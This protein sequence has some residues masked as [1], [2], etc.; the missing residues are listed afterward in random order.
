MLS[1]IVFVVTFLI[2]VFLPTPLTVILTI[3]DMLI[4]DPIPFADE[5][6]LALSLV[7]KVR[8]S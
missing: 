8:K 2:G 6:G 4:P 1:L 5:I 7:V 3:A